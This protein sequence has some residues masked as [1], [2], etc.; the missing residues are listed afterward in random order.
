MIRFD[1]DVIWIDI[2]EINV[3]ADLERF[4]D[5]NVLSILVADLDVV[6][7]DL[8]PI[9]SHPRFPNA[10]LRRRFAT[11]LRKVFV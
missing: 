1:A 6:D 11:I 10:Q 4:A 7:A 8:R 2:A 5:E 9:F 3:R